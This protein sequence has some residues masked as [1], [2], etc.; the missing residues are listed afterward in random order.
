MKA[1]ASRRRD[2][3]RRPLLRNRG[4]LL[5]RRLRLASVLRLHAS[6]AQ[7]DLHR[8]LCLEPVAPPPLGLVVEPVPP[9]PPTWFHSMRS[10]KSFVSV[11]AALDLVHGNVVPADAAVPGGRQ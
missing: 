8:E 3:W 7:A 11:V 9:R 6:L 2:P 5:V 10:T 1:G 4:R